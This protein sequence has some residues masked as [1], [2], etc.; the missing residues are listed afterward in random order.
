MADCYVYVYFRDEIPFYVGMGHGDRDIQH[1][2]HVL[3]RRTRL[4]NDHFH[5]ILVKLKR[6]GHA[7]SIIRV[8]ENLSRIEAA[9]IEINLIAKYGRAD[10]GNGPLANKTDGG[11]GVTGWSAEAKQRQSEKKKGK[12]IVVDADGHKFSVPKDHPDLLAGILKGQN[13]GVKYN[14]QNQIGYI[15]A[16]DAQGVVTR[17]RQ[18]DPR[19]ISGELVGVQHGRKIKD[20]MKMSEAQMGIPKPKPPGFAEKMREIALAREAKKREAKGQV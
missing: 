17:V 3:N 18:D 1:W 13:S 6:N 9:E 20:T 14:G 4:K 10:L 2:N 11:D 15:Q 16:K 7:P 5:N 19:W 12:V 8:A